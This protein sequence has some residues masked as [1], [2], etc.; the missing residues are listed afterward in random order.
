MRLS[1]D[2]TSIGSPLHDVRGNASGYR[3]VVT[4]HR[5]STLF[6]TLF[7]TFQAQRGPYEQHEQIDRWV[8]DDPAGARLTRDSIQESL[9]ECILQRRIPGID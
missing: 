5:H 7:Q 4:R 2:P 6:V 3:L 9:A 8:A 1:V